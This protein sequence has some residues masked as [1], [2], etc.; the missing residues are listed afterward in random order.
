MTSQN[1]GV[2]IEM[3]GITRCAAAKLIAGYFSSDATHVGGRAC[4]NL[5]FATGR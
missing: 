5:V 1:F 4:R 3:T 2:E